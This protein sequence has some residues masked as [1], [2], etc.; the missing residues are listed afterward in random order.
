MIVATGIMVGH[1]V[2]A[3]QAL[4]EIGVSATVLDVH[5]LKPFNAADVA[6][7][8]R[9]HRVVLTVEEH[10]VEGGL[11]SMVLEALAAA[12]VRV[13]AFKHGLQDEYAIVGPPTHLYQYYGLDPEGIATVAGRALNRA[14][15]GQEGMAQLWSVEDRERVK[16]A[17]AS[18]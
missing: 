6:E 13:P 5:T 4:Q 8:A 12:A 17:V 3:A 2:D 11:G 18:E 1:A 9:N 10:N 14:V 15:S 16:D 7:H